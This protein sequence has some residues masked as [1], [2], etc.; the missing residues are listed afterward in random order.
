M[1]KILGI[2]FIICAFTQTGF[3]QKT[4]TKA[5]AKEVVKEIP[6]EAID[7]AVEAKKNTIL[8]GQTVTLTPQDEE[9]FQRLFE[10]KYR[11]L[12]EK[13]TEERKAEL[14]NII[15]MKIRA[16]LSAD[17]MAKLDAKP[18]VLKKLKS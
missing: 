8:L 2:A 10:Y 3:A 17:Q 5:I 15:E 14:A 4:T 18:E 6:K 12:N 1:K 16:S 11:L 9:N 13:L 7:V